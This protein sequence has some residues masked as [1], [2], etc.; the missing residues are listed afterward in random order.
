MKNATLF[1]V[2]ALL[3]AAVPN[4]RAAETHDKAQL[5]QPEELAKILQTKGEKP[6]IL[7]V[8]FK[9]LYAQAHIP[10]AEYI[11]PTSEE[12]GMAQLRERAKSL[13]KTRSIVL[14][15]GCCPWGHCPNIDP[16][17]KYLREQGFT[18]VKALYLANNF[19]QDWMNKGY[20]VEKGQ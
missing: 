7:M 12:R 9:V 13:S 8:G 19:G 17:L 1:I 6:V 3:W 5:I 16:A 18:N 10:G 20:P 11:G 15:C 2:L 14:Y 4:L